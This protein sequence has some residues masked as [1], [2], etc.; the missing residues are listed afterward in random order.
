MGFYLGNTLAESVRVSRDDLDYSRR[1]D[2]TGRHHTGDNDPGNSFIP[3][4]RP[5]VVYS[6]VFVS[7]PITRKYPPHQ[8]IRHGR[9]P[10][11]K[12]RPLASV[13]GKQLIP[14][15]RQF[16]LDRLARPR[17]VQFQAKDDVTGHLAV[18]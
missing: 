1:D 16:I 11:I 17:V 4:G 8:R 7:F 18:S 9:I 13:I 14:V 3:H 5:P 15:Q 2:R 12:L 10:P 6:G